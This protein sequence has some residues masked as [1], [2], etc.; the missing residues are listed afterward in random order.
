LATTAYVDGNP[1]VGA[2]DTFVSLRLAYDPA[3]SQGGGIGVV[4]RRPYVVAPSTGTYVPHVTTSG[5]TNLTVDNFHYLG[6]R[7]TGNDDGSNNT[8]SFTGH[9]TTS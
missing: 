7:V 1:W 4:F 3:G 2:Q 6:C 8:P 5:I 9:V